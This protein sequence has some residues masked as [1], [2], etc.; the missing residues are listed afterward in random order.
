MVWSTLL[1]AFTMAGRR[2]PKTLPPLSSLLSL[3]PGEWWGLGWACCFSQPQ[4]ATPSLL[5]HPTSGLREGCFFFTVVL[6]SIPC[7]PLSPL[8]KSRPQHSFLPFSTFFFPSVLESL[9]A[10]DPLHSDTSLTLC[11]T[12]HL[13]PSLP[14]PALP[15]MASPLGQPPPIP[16]LSHS[17]PLCCTAVDTATAGGLGRKDSRLG[18][19]QPQK[20]R[21][22][23]QAGISAAPFKSCKLA[24]ALCRE[25]VCL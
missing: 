19:L 7:I 11:C 1:T 10:S 17:P 20:Q 21:T 12:P 25:S 23:R 18:Q 9:S 14:P 15:H 3:W 5:S 16:S 8:S 2:S 24:V 22:S 4:G 13:F 6:V